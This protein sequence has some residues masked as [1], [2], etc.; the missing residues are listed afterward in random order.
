MN[1]ALLQRLRRS[2]AD[3]PGFVE[4]KMMGG[5]CVMVRGHMCC[6]IRDDRLMVRVGPE[7]Y[8]DALARP[9]VGP[10]RIGERCPKGYIVVASDA[11]DDVGFHEWVSAGLDYVATLPE[12]PDARAS[13]SPRNARSKLAR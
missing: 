2:L 13:R 6:G 4:R 11:L 8:A 1:D 10:L 7:R 9:H 5:V 3:S 12:K